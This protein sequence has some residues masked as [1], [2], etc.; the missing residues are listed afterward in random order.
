[1]GWNTI[2]F[3]AEGDPSTT[4][5]PAFED[6]WTPTD[7]ELALDEASSSGLA[8]DMAFAEVKGWSALWAPGQETLA[9]VAELVDDL[10]VAGRALA[11]VLSGVTSSYGFLWSIDGEIT[12]AIYYADDEP[13]IDRGAALPE[14]EGIDRPSWGY[15]EDWIFTIVSRLTGI[16]YQDLDAA[17]YRRLGRI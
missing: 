17:T 10:S 4:L 2:A 15:D 7:N 12:R 11:V 1:M 3:F 16:S 13:A 14:E 5:M 6:S 8:P 9:E